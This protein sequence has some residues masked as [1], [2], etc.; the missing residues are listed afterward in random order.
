MAL[1][2]GPIPRVAVG[3]IIEEN[4]GDSVAQSLNNLGERRD[5]GNWNPETTYDTTTGATMSTWFNFGGSTATDLVIPDWATIATIRIE[6]NGVVNSGTPNSTYDLQMYIGTEGG[7]IIRM[8][9][10]SDSGYFPIGWTDRFADLPAPGDRLLK[11]QVAKV[12]GASPS[13]HWTIGTTADVYFDA[14]YGGAIGWYPG[15]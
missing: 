12:S 2:T 4:W 1:P 14:L 10:T 3:E 13:G 9:A 11:V 15:L 7:R 5:A 6:I 8:T